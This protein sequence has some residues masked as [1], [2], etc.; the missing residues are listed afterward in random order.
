MVTKQTMLEIPFLEYEGTSALHLENHEKS[1]EI[2]RNICISQKKVVPLQ[3]KFGIGMFK[4]K[5]N[6]EIRSKKTLSALSLFSC[7]GV[8]EYYLRDLGIDIICSSD[9]DKARCH[10]HKFL[11]PHCEPVC[12]DITRQS[13]KQAIFNHIGDKTID[14]IISTP[15][16]Q[17]M[18]TVG[19]NRKLESLLN[20]EDERNYL[21][22]ETFPFIEKY[23]PSYVVFENVPRLLKV[24]LPYDGKLMTVMDILQARYGDEYDIKFNIYNTANFEIPQNRERVFIRM[25]KKGLVW[26]NPIPSNHVI[27]L[28]EAIGD[29]PPLEAGEHSNIKN[30]W[31]RKH[32]YNQIQWM[33]HT[34]TGGS[35]MDNEVFYPQKS[36]GERITAY[37]NCYRRIEWDKPSPT[38]TMRNEIMSSQ[39]NVHPGRLLPNGLWSDARVLSLRELLIIMSLPADLDLPTNVSDTAIR[40]Y[41]GE[42]IPS[43]MMKK[44][45][46]GLIC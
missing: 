18:S 3:P 11:Y 1:A 29:L 19:K 10:I 43:L 36:N 5:P 14:L 34:P 15:P 4:V 8:S 9:I 41:I 2:A 44:V 38:I 17:G 45:M 23:R 20:N 27:S 35:A 13:V 40:Q 26:A 28:R 42:G 25:C 16:C 37:H 7:I 24:L 6:T 31:A 21:I 33:Q 12:G 32:P 30:H 22:F 46:E 39:D